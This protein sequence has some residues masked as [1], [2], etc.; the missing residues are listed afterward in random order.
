MPPPR[1][2]ASRPALIPLQDTFFRG[3]MTATDDRSSSMLIL[4]SSV[5]GGVPGGGRGW[6]MCGAQAFI[7]WIFAKSV[8]NSS[9]LGA[10]GAPA[11]CAER[12]TMGSRPLQKFG[13]VGGLAYATCGSVWLRRH[14]RTLTGRR[15]RYYTAFACVALVVYRLRRLGYKSLPEAINHRYGEARVAGG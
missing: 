12:R 15:R 8:Q 10:V 6:L 11:A 2:P 14:R 5:G 3:G 13:V 1:T 9:K 4:S 7:S